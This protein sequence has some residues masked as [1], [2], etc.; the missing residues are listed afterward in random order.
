M[1]IVDL[2]TEVFN[3]SGRLGSQSATYSIFALGQS[4][5]TILV[6]LKTSIMKSLRFDVIWAV[7][8]VATTVMITRR[9]NIYTANVLM[10][11]LSAAQVTWL[12]TII[13]IVLQHT[14]SIAESIEH[15][16]D[17]SRHTAFHLWLMMYESSSCCLTWKPWSL[18]ERSAAN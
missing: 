5:E 1:H 13:F 3:T 17:Q 8:I 4:G 9:C 2:P 14:S 15:T 12:I 18:L 7:L 11:I 16:Q 6:S 10:W